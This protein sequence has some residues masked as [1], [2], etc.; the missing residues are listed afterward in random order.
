MPDACFEHGAVTIAGPE[1]P[2][3]G[4]SA[5]LFESIADDPSASLVQVQGGGTEAATGSEFAGT[6]SSHRFSNHPS[7]EVL[8]DVVETISPTHVVVTHQQGKSL[9]R[10]KDKWDS[11][12]W[13]TGSRGKEVLYRDGTYVAPP[14][15]TEYVERRVR[16]RAGQFDADRIDAALLDAV[17]TAPAAHRRESVELGRED[18]D[19]EALREQL[20][21]RSAP[22]ASME[23]VEAT[24]GGSTQASGAASSSDSTIETESTEGDIV[25]EAEEQ[26]STSDDSSGTPVSTNALTVTVDPAIGLLAQQ[27]GQAAET[28]LAV[29]VREAVDAYIA[30]ILR[31]D[32]PWDD[33]DAEVEALSLDAGP[34][35]ST[36]LSSA[37]AEGESVEAFALEHLRGA[38]GVDDADGA[39]PI[40]DDGSIAALL[41]AVVENEDTP[42]ESLADVVED[43][44]RKQF[45]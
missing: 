32:E 36:L 39:V 14:W 7:E 18:V 38:V 16:N 12:S 23:S 26:T 41:G 21:I 17:D 20:H 10:Y 42:S 25:S 24:D 22:K 6:V 2:V 30:D 5:R 9:E 1:V 11:F 19:V 29:F 27:R 31:G 40:R 33:L 37:T 35:L 13:P 44:L 15:V 45:Q 34:V 8:D 3:E 4:S 28:P 43:A